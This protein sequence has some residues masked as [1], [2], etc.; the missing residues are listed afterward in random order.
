MVAAM[1]FRT[2]TIKGTPLVQLVE[3]FRNAEGQPRQ[4][5][6]VSLGEAR[7]P[8]SEKHLIARAV[9]SHLLG[10]ADLLSADLSE[11]AT[12]WVRRILQLAGRSKSA[13]PVYGETVD[14][15]VVERVESEN[16]VQLGPQLA[17]LEAWNHLDLTPMLAQAGLNPSQIATAQL[18]V[19]NR[20]IEP[21]SEWA[22]IDWAERTALPEMRLAEGIFELENL[23]ADA[24][25]LDAVGHLPG[26]GADALVPGDVIEEFEMVDVH[27]LN[28][29]R[30]IMEPVDSAA[31]R[32]N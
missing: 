24:G 23:A 12:T 8:E 2:K 17:A 1:F 11:E 28:V 4:R 22:L 13:R 25:L 3:A 30:G 29:V 27:G 16:V 7:L 15:V 18:L 10:Q 20:L 19:A 32:I 14:G 5:V 26:R 31:E 9:G 6:V 21:S